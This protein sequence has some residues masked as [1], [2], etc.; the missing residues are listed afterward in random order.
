MTAKNKTP[1]YKFLKPSNTHIWIL[2]ALLKVNSFLPHL[3][4]INNGK[5][6]GRV[7]HKFLAK[8]RAISRKNLSLAFPNLKRERINKITAEHFES[9]GASIAELGIC[10]WGKSKILY[11]N[12]VWEGKEH[13]AKA[14]EANK[15]IILL[16]AHFT[17]LEVSGLLLQFEFPGFAVV[18]RKNRNPFITEIFRTTRESFAKKA[19]EKREIKNM[20]RSL[21]NGGTVWYAPD[22]SYNRKQSSVI[23]FFGVPSMTNIA[24]STIAK[25]GN[26]VVLPFFPRRLENGNY[27]LSF[28]APLE[29]FPSNDPVEDTKKYIDLLEKHIKVCPEQYYWLHKKYKNLPEQYTD[30]YADLKNW[31]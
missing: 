30:Y 12:S 15:G 11:E 17:T 13:I 29:D 26:A 24:T 7:L 23:P 8:R 18:Y 2:F 28:K 4:Q 5:F 20:I 21:R 22:Q 19:I 25:L 14:R 31:A 16:S 1:L 3:M 27:V 10:R 9:V 6:L